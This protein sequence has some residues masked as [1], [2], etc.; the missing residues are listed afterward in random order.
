M[1]TDA[2]VLIAGAGPTGLLLANELGL[3]GVRTA[4]VERLPHRTGRSK[5][6]NL[7]PRTVEVLACRGWP[8][9]VLDRSPALLPA[10][11]FAGLPL[12]YGALDTAFPHQ[13]GIPQARVEEFLEDHLAAYGVPVLRGR[14]LRSFRQDADGVTATLFGPDGAERTVRAGYLVGADGGRSTVRRVLGMPFPGRDGRVGMAVADI[15]LSAEEGESGGPGEP[16]R[17]PDLRPDPAG[18]AFLLPLGDGV[19]RLFLGGPEQQGV[20]RDAP[21]TADEV[22]VALTRC[23]GPP[24]TLR[25]VR[26][27]SR[28][29]DASRQAERYADGRVL[30]AGD[31]AHIHAPAGGQGLNLGMQDAFNLG[32]KLA[33]VVRGDAPDGLLATYHAERHPVGARVLAN[34]RAQMVLTLPDPDAVVVRE[35]LADLL[36]TPEA[37]RRVAAMIAGTDIRYPMPGVPDHPLLGARAPGVRLPAGRGALLAD[38]PSAVAA[39]AEGW[40][41]RVDHGPAAD[42]GEALLVRPDGYVCWAGRDE[43]ADG[44]RAALARW[45]GAPRSLAGSPEGRAPGR[46]R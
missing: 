14:E 18:V 25:A 43:D 8:A 16:W 23:P 44:L 24:R 46:P 31:A 45:F 37:N 17:L 39:A 2:E 34:T 4:V 22:R 13:I 28:F 10:G 20:D 40:A 6:L 1:D 38:A 32:W 41:D 33:A 19:H 9:P 21:V 5:A 29:T 26:W 3:A 12:D 36:T 11:H 30:L 42:G 7:Q 35:L 27:A 15:E